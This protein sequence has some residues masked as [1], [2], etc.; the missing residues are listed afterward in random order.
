MTEDDLTNG[1]RQHGWDELLEH[2]VGIRGG[3][4]LQPDYFGIACASAPVGP[5]VDELRPRGSEEQERA[6]DVVENGFEQVEQRPL[7]PV[8]VFDRHDGGLV[9]DELFQEGD[10]RLAKLITGG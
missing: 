10:P 6:A 5:A 2:E 8:Q 7:R 9:H 1:G 3:Q 4:R